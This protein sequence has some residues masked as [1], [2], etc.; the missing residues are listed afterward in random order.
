[1]IDDNEGQNDDANNPPTPTTPPAPVPVVQ[2]NDDVMRAYQQQLLET[3]R[4]NNELRKRLDELER[5]PAAPP[6]PEEEKAF[7]DTPRT[8]TAEIVRRELA[9]Q[10][11]PINKF[12]Q[13][14]QRDTVIA[15][16]KTQM[17]SLASQ[18]PYL[19]LV[20]SIFDQVM[21]NTAQIDQSSVINA[22]NLAVGHY[23]ST[24]GRLENN[25]PAAPSN[26]VHATHTPTTNNVPNPPRIPPSAPPAPVNRN[27]GKAKRVLN[28]NEKK[29]A[30]YNGMTEEQY[31]A[32]TD[33]VRPSEVASIS[34]DEIKV[35]ATR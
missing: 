16:Y 34:D 3:S 11:E 32:W 20:E 31:I 17:R 18:F 15:N 23:V 1:M 12:V 4:T 30:R 2:Q 19:G 5:K 29:I 24:G 27:N 9:T 6:T 25:T 8:T 14:M 26:A 35:R 10:V 21:A 33:D 13:Q 28:E 7:F 22:Y